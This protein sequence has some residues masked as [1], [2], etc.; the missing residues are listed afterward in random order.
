MSTKQ[1]DKFSD[2]EEQAHRE[3]NAVIIEQVIHLLGQPTNLQTVQ[4]RQLWKDH[5]RVN[6][7]TGESI[8]AATVANS[9]F[10]ETNDDGGIVASTPKITRKY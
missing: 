5:Y 6:V 7:Y 3:L 10:L 1:Q 8:A 2:F 4:V 9:Y